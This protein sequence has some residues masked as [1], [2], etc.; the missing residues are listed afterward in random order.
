M[1]IL[2]IAFIVG[3]AG[4]S[5]SGGAQTTPSVPVPIERQ[6][7]GVTPREA[8]DLIAKLE[9]A[10]RLLRA[11]KFQSFEL[12]AGSI[13]SYD[14]TKVSPREAFLQ[15]PFKSV[16]NVERVRSDNKLAQPYRLAY[17]P[18]GLGKLYWDIEVVLDINNNIDR[19]S[20]TYR[21]PAP[22]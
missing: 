1:G 15:V 16:W 22:F 9:D 7:S 19:V 14:K 8:T 17:A 4:Q 21:P 11:G 12:L 3:L 13:A 10:Q 6:L 2:Q 5:V 18:D 20:M